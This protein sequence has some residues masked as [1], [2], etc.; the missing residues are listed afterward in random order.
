MARLLELRNLG[1][2][3][4]K[5]K[6]FRWLS[7]EGHGLGEVRFFVDRVQQR[8]LGFRGPRADLFTLVF[9]AK[10]IGDQF[11]PKNAIAIAQRRKAEIEADDQ[12][13][14]E[15]WLFPDP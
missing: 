1:P 12:Y 8:P 6:L 2:R 10:E 13:A 4:W 14:N 5:P 7:G 15:C 11:V 9:P 3:D